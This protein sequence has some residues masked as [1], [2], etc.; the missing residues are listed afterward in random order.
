MSLRNDQILSL[1]F[2]SFKCMRFPP[3]FRKQVPGISLAESNN[4]KRKLG[5]Y[6]LISNLVHLIE[7]IMEHSHVS[8]TA[9]FFGPHTLLTEIVV[10]RDD[11]R[12]APAHAQALRPSPMHPTS[13]HGIFQ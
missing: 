4:P 6:V 5:R 10:N 11:V 12:M 3:M 7:G 9:K 8:A 13:W 1:T 2:I